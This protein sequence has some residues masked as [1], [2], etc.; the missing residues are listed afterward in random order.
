MRESIETVQLGGR[1]RVN[2]KCSCS[3]LKGFYLFSMFSASCTSSIGEGGA[4]GGG[5]GREREYEN[6]VPALEKPPSQE[7]ET[8]PWYIFRE[9][10]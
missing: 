5:Q 2:I 8:G 9:K 7:G 3:F 1:H 4:G 6:C 10:S